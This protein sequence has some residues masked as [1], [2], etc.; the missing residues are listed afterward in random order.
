MGHVVEGHGGGVEAAV[1]AGPPVGR[2]LRHQ[3]VPHRLPVAAPAVTRGGGGGVGEGGERERGRRGCRGSLHARRRHLQ[4]SRF[5]RFPPPPW[6]HLFLLPSQAKPPPLP[7]LLR[8]T[9]PPIS[10]LHEPNCLDSLAGPLPPLQ[11][12]SS[13][14]PSLTPANAPSPIPPH[15]PTHVHTC[16]AAARSGAPPACTPPPSSAAPA[17]P[18]PPARQ[19]AAR[20]APVRVSGLG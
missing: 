5:V 1:E 6:P 19:P 20:V 17:P 16:R 10:L 7:L 9:F 3:P 11:R 8:S 15:P 13:I 18:R 14:P 12:L 4:L 2:R